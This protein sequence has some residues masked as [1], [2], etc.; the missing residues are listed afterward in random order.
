MTAVVSVSV[1]VSLS[2]C[3]CRMYLNNGISITK[4]QIAVSF[5]GDISAGPI[6]QSAH[7]TLSLTP[8]S[9]SHLVIFSVSLSLCND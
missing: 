7:L 9:L 1:Y 5:A 4:A 8:L 3:I 6:C 2:V